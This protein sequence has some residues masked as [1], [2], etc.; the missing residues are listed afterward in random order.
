MEQEL[1]RRKRRYEGKISVSISTLVSSLSH[2]KGNCQSVLPTSRGKPMLVSFYFRT[3]IYSTEFLAT[4]SG[5]LL[6]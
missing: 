2:K 5:L 3:C 1:Y 4:P 6:V